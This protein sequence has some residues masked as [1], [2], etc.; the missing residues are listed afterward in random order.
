M[1]GFVRWPATLAS[2]LVVFPARRF[3]SSLSFFARQ[4][5][6]M[7]SSNGIGAG[8]GVAVFIKAIVV[9]IDGDGLCGVGAQRVR[10][11]PRDRAR[12]FLFLFVAWCDSTVS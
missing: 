1:Q 8:F 7:D 10:G 3:L 9:M 6:N 11:H 2:P 4:A 5:P 12:T